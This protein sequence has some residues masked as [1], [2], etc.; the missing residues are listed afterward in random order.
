MGFRLPDDVV[1]PL[2]AMGFILAFIVSLTAFIIYRKNFKQ[3]LSPSEMSYSQKFSDFIMRGILFSAISWWCIF[4]LMFSIYLLILSFSSNF[5]PANIF[6]SIAVFVLIILSGTLVCFAN[7]KRL[8]KIKSNVYQENKSKRI[9]F[10]SLPP[11]GKICYVATIV[12][13]PFVLSIQILGFLKGDWLLIRF[14]S[15]LMWTAV[16]SPLI[17]WNIKRK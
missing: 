12:L 6:L 4:I 2:G 9:R 16:A 14:V 15:I 8:L 7:M 5:T 3:T 10:S 17:I 11:W 1:G 13:L